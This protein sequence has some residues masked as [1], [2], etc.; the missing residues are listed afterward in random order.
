MRWI[1]QDDEDSSE[2]PVTEKRTLREL[3]RCAQIA[4]ARW[5]LSGLDCPDEAATDGVSEELAV[6]EGENAGWHS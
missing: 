5:L 2:R 6:L 4:I 3:R 1:A